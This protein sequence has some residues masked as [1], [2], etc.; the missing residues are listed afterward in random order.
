MGGIVGAEGCNMSRQLVQYHKNNKKWK[1]V[2]ETLKTLYAYDSGAVEGM[3][4]AGF[5]LNQKINLKAHL[6]ELNKKSPKQLKTNIAKIAKELYVTKS[7]VNKNGIKDYL[8]WL[9]YELDLYF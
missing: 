6:A 7:A 5:M 3:P 4:N 2:G 8:E 9:A 1:E